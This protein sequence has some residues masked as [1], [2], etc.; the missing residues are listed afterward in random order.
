MSRLPFDRYLAL[1]E[2]ESRRFRDVLADCDPAARVPGC[3]AWDAADL[4]WHLG[5]VQGFWA[6]VV[7]HRPASPRDGYDEPARPTSYADLLTLFDEHA[8]A[9]VTALGEADPGEAAW[10]WAPEQ[11][12]GFTYRRQSLEALVHRVD[13]EQTAGVSSPL[14]PALA[15][16]GV[17]EVLD[18]MYGGCPDWGTFS[19]L[20]HLLRV[21]TTD[22]GESVW[23]R[24][25]RFSGTDPES[26]T[27][28][29]EDDISVVDDPDAEPDAVI[30]GTAQDLLLRLWRRGDGGDTRLAGNLEIVDRFRQVVHQPIN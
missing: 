12:V 27:S 10:S 28:Y 15:T 1:L 21:D 30:S 7:A 20:P 24:L 22:T 13:A 19:P 16:D 23:V 11:T 6:W 14:D 5:E 29:D 9:L 25:G 3:P 4:L 18:V 26:G 2:T 8:A 17:E